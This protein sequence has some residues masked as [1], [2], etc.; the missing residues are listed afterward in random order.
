M[1]A[2]K[3]QVLSIQRKNEEL[4]QHIVSLQAS[5]EHVD[6]EV[7]HIHGL[8]SHLPK[9]TEAAV[10]TGTP[11][12]AQPSQPPLRTPRTLD[13]LRSGGIFPEDVVKPSPVDLAIPVHPA[14]N[15]GFHTDIEPELPPIE[16]MLLP[17]HKVVFYMSYRLD[18]RSRELTPGE[19]RFLPHLK[20]NLAGLHPTLEEFSGKQPIRL[21][22]FLSIVTDGLRTLQASEAVGIRLLNYLLEGDAQHFYKSLSSHGSVTRTPTGNSLGHE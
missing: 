1:D 21:L 13:E 20:K 4:T 3:E 8:W 17:F 10:P 11:G 18:L 6:W 7:A 12:V 16:I 22:T 9:P 19:G 2:L 5:M 15:N 14:N